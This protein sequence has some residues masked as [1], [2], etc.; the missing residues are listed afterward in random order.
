MML[1]GSLLYSFHALLSS[2]VLGIFPAASIDLAEVLTDSSWEFKGV[3]LMGKFGGNS[4]PGR[5][6]SGV[7]D[8]LYLMVLMLDMVC[9]DTNA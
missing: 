9:L 2:L 1:F 7:A 5:A 3:L 6:F 4:G 8:I